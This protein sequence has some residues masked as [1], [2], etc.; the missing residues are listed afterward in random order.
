M[1]AAQSVINKKAGLG[2]AGYSVQSKDRRKA[3]AKNDQLAITTG[4]IMLRSSLLES[5]KNLQKNIGF[6][7][8]LTNGLTTNMHPAILWR[9]LLAIVRK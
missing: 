4:R 8:Y 9:H 3:I 6:Y 2:V 5:M 7:L 1:A